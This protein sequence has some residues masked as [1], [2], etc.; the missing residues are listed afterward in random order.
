MANRHSDMQRGTY[1]MNGPA[2]ARAVF[3]K[4]GTTMIKLWRRMERLEA[5]APARLDIEADIQ[6]A[7]A[8]LSEPDIWERDSTLAQEAMVALWHV[9]GPEVLVLAPPGNKTARMSS[10]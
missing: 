4:T 3:G 6:A 7:T 5:R 9:Y 1:T 10:S 8:I 2:H